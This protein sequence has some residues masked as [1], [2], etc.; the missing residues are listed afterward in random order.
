[1]YN[2]CYSEYR[3]DGSLIHYK[4]SFASR[5]GALINAHLQVFLNRRKRLNIRI[6]HL[7]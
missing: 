4:E 1:M 5:L 6:E 2:V 7:A 3:R